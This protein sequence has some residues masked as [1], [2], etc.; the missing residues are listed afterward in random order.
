MEEESFIKNIK[1]VSGTRVYKINNSYGVYDYYKYYRKNKPKDKKYVLTESQ[2]FKIIRLINTYLIKSF[3]DG[4]DIIFPCRMGRLEL[5][6]LKPT[7]K[8]E[9]SKVKTNLPIDWN[10]T[11]KL[12]YEDPDCFKNKTLVRIPETEVFKIHY[13]KSDANFNNK[14]FYQFIANREF[15]LTL[16]KNI[17]EGNIDAFTF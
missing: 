13:N 15:K 3:I 6:K 11:L 9:G 1:K 14:S 17:K 8:M 5:R 16:K 7:I 10:K 4:K 2:Y 12:W